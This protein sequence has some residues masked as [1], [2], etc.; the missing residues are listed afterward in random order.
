[1][2]E[3]FPFTPKIGTIC[4]A[5]YS[6]DLKEEYIG[7]ECKMIFKIVKNL[8]DLIKVFIVRG[9]VFVEEQCI[10]YMIERDAYDCSST[11]ILGEQDGEPFAAGRIRLCGGYAKLERI[12]IRKSF[13]GKNLGHRLTD[14]MIRVAKEQGFQRFK[15]H[16][17]VHLAE[18]YQ[19]HGFI[20]YGGV[21]QEAGI[22]HYIMIRDDSRSAIESVYQ[23]D[24]QG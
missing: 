15:V 20:I 23:S 16:A 6:G 11:H 10:P 22:D 18:F 12:A 21:F 7:T 17:Q 13:R 2:G 14:F 9:I 3:R 24:K 8:D 5:E 4:M 1:M 19:R